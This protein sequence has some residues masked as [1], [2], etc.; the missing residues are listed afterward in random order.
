MCPMNCLPTVCGM[1]VEVED[2]RVTAVHGDPG[3]PESRGFLCIRG[4]AAG[5]IVDNP[6]RLLR[7]RLRDR[8]GDGPWRDT[9]W[10]DA[11]DRIAAAIGSA[12]PHRT[13]V[14][15]GHG[16]FVNTVGASLSWRFANL[17]GAQWW[18][19]SIVCWGLGGLGVWLTGLPHVNTAD[20]LAENADLVV[21]WGANLASQPTTAPRI[22]AARR[23]G[24]RVIAIDVRRTEACDH[25]D[26]HLLLRP[27]TDAALALAVAHVI[28]REGLED[29]DFIERHTV[30]S[31]A[32][33]RHVEGC[34]PEWAEAET[35]LAAARIRA[36]AREYAGSRRATI[37]LGG[38]SMHKTANR[39]HAARAVSCLPA[40][41]GNLG[42]PGA[43]MGP[44][45]GAGTQSTALARIV[46][47]DIRS[48]E[49]VI[50]S[51]MDTILDRLEAG[52]V[53]VL[54]LPGTNMLS[55]FS[56]TA[57]VERALQRVGL[58]VCFDL[59]MSD[60]SRRFADV[61]LPGTSW[62]EETGLKLGPTHV[63][64]MDRVL[65]PRGEARPAWQ[66]YAGLAERLGLE[67]YF[68]WGSA[69]G[70][71]DAVLD[72][73]HTRHVTVEQLRADG[74]SAATAAA[75]YA[76]GS[77]RF[78]TPSGKVELYSERALAMGLPPL[79]VHETPDRPAGHPLAFVQ[80]RT[81]THFHGFY[82]H[83][84]ALPSLARADP[85]PILWIG[86]EDAAARDIEDGE[87]VRLHNER[88]AMEARARVT[89]RVPAGVVWM[90]DGWLGVNQLTSSERTVPDA[91]VAAF[92]AGGS[93]R[94]DA[95]VEVERAVAARPGPV[96]SR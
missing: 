37:L 31:E 69:E 6:L 95:F 52:D 82:D 55:S 8:R 92:P 90:R 70:L 22:V 87:P 43:G 32:L 91:A 4:R 79:P 42:R 5:E 65:E 38:S 17:L 7:P 34:T 74:P 20:D 27:G 88:G 3:N 60:T 63:H 85:E 51:E 26:D 67:G 72:S 13:A 78:P 86:P 66:L 33:A 93:A 40:L 24:A 25:A 89:D 80:G 64:L 19:P 73:D 68:P 50:P 57:R 9:T 14:W 1:R 28:F 41:T 16:V 94:Y 30:G 75:A 62:L 77:L 29:R 48:P 54:L 49:T 61:V 15:P 23:R 59:F 2:G 47:P 45:H 46:P 83:G 81:L 96:G 18:V 35:G 10:D 44:R 71:V 76:Y 21:L 84:Q 39:W 58:I 12:P 53:Q 36:F 11:L 56:D